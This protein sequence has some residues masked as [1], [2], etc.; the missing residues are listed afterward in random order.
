MNLVKVPKLSDIYFFCSQLINKGEPSEQDLQLVQANILDVR[1]LGAF[2]EHSWPIDKRTC[3][4]EIL[5]SKAA[6]LTYHLFEGN[7]F[8]QR[9]FLF[10]L[11]CGISMMKFNDIVAD[12][13]I[14]DKNIKNIMS[15]YSREKGP[16]FCMDLLKEFFLKSF[17]KK[18]PFKSFGKTGQFFPR[19]I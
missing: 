10:S 2:L 3:E 7:F 14:L 13:K 8:S 6:Y 16:T 5:P 4:L 11:W 9:K 12:K 1:R 18:D 15:L 17:P 19:L